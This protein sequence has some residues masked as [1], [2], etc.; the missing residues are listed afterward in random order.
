MGEYSSITR[1]G[2][3]E[4]FELHVQRG[5][6]QEHKSVSKFGYATSVS[7]TEVAVFNPWKIAKVVSRLYLISPG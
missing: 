5:Y 2:K 7:G 4:P 6:V 1:T 3:H